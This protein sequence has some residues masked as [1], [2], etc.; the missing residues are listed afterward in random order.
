MRLSAAI[1]GN[2]KAMMAAEVK[3]AE[4]AVSGGVRQATD[5][6]KNELRGQVTGAGLGERLAKSWRGEL[7]PKGGMSIN[8][9][10]F[11]Y[12]KAQQII[13]AFAYGVTIRSKQGRFLAIPTPYVTRRQN[14][15]ITPADFAE[16]GIQLRYVP[17]QGNRRVGL[18]VADDFRVTSKGK[19]RVASDRA[20]KTGRGLTTVVM[21]ILVPQ[22][23]LKNASTSTA[24]PK[25][26][27]TACRRS[28]RQ[29]GP[30]K[31]KKNDHQRNDFASLVG[32]PE[33]HF[34]C[35]CSAQRGVA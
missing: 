27:S 32:A 6:L 33:N 7:Y 17:P 19:A 4:R 24:L 9:A 18:L 3:A 2:L 25:N 29:A 30:T 1:Q 14:K 20:K 15:K 26:G 11:V 28:S 13:G 8:A 12:T 5:G 34:R 35:D 21:F 31:R 16:A 10:G 23:A 22:A